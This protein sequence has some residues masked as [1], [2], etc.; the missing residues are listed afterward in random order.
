MKDLVAHLQRPEGD[1]R[2]DMWI[3]LP[4]T[5]G[6]ITCTHRRIDVS[7]TDVT[8]LAIACNRNN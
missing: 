1:E 4:S 7:P 5:D 3:V 2:Y 6:K 8:K